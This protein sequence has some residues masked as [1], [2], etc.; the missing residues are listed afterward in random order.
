MLDRLGKI[1]LHLSKYAKYAL[2]VYPRTKDD[3]NG[4]NGTTSTP[5]R[6]IYTYFSK[7][8]IKT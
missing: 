4:D 2:F 3:T 6:I 8:D 7:L 1:D 5:K